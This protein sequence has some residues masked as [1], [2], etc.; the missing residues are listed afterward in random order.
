M[1][2]GRAFLGP[3]PDILSIFTMF[4]LDFHYDTQGGGRPKAAPIMGNLKKNIANIDKMSGPGPKRARPGRIFGA[5]R[6][7]RKTR[8]IWIKK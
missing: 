6:K 1:S 7:A 2:P 8:G 5:L 4:D 3:G